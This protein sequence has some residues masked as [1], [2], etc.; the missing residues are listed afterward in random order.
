M[1]RWRE[2]E[3]E[4]EEVVVEGNFVCCRWYCRGRRNGGMER[5]EKGGGG[6][7]I[8][9]YLC[10]GLH[11][12]THGLSASLIIH[13]PRE[14]STEPSFNFCVSS[15]G[16]C[17]NMEKY[18]I[19]RREEDSLTIPPSSLPFRTLYFLSLVLVINNLLSHGVCTLYI[20]IC[21]AMS[22]SL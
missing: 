3:G 15:P 9:I 20:Y 1:A 21:D 5:E 12:H 14:A 19:T 8:M 18:F 2:E 7:R 11:T 16:N 10:A 13:F 4:E 6:G 22:T 17:L